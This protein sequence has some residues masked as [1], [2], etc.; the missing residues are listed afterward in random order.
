MTSNP[1]PGLQ[2]L[3]PAVL[4]RIGNLELV[5]RTVV[6]G[7]LGGLHRSPHLGT[8]IDFAEHRAYMPGDDIRRIDWRLYGRVDRYYIKEYEADTNTNFNVLLDVS[9]SMSFGS[10]AVTKLDYARTLAACLSYF[11]NQQRDRVGLITWDEDI[12]E[13][14]PPSAKHLPNVLHALARA[15]P[16]GP[17]NIERVFRKLAEQFKRRSMLLVISDFYEDPAKILDAF[18]QLRGRGNDLMAMHLLDTAE[19]EFPYDGATSFEDIETGERIP[20]IPEYLRD[21]YRTMIRAHTERIEKLCGDQGVDYWM[22]NTSMPLD[23]ALFAFLSR[24]Q[25]LTRVR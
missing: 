13:I 24:R 8:S 20:V 21:Q 2:F 15:T 17:G 9:K 12:V 19:L 11:A 22:F 5:A 3:D 4:A 10:A 6:E 1:L 18:A 16:Q 23:Y 25:F 14:V 7:F